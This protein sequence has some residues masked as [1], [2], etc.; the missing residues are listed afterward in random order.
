MI[1][2]VIVLEPGLSHL[3]NLQ[4]LLVFRPADTWK[5]CGKT[6]VPLARNAGR[7][8]TSPRPNSRRRGS[9]A[10][11]N[12]SIR[13]AR[14]TSKPSVNRISARKSGQRMPWR[15]RVR[16]RL[17]RPRAGRRSYL[18]DPSE[19]ASMGRCSN[20]LTV[21]PNFITGQRSEEQGDVIDGQLGLFS[22]LTRSPWFPPPWP[23]R[24]RGWR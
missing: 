3:Q 7:T 16:R 13:T 6:Y 20:S 15:R 24:Q 12:S 5:S 14:L 21:S 1:P 23:V 10:A 11:R 19:V 9:K 17:R 4:R 22:D 18:L 8:G 2:H